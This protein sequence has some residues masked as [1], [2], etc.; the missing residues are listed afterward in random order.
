MDYIHE[1]GF[2]RMML[3]S[4]MSDSQALL[5]GSVALCQPWRVR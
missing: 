4:N 1:C 2:M 3:T 5:R